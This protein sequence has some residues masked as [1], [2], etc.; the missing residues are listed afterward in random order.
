[1]PKGRCKATTSKKGPCGQR[2][3]PSGYCH[4][5]N[6]ALVEAKR[7]EA[8]AI[9]AKSKRLNEALAVLTDT[10]EARGWSW[11]IESIDQ[12]DYRY[13]SFNVSRLIDNGSF[14][15]QVT[16]LCEVTVDS[17]VKVSVQKTSFHGYG[18]TVL[19]DAFSDALGRLPWLESP[20]KKPT[21]QTGQPPAP[22][23]LEPL[24]RRFPQIVRQLRRRH[25]DRPT[26]EISDEYD[27]QD[28]LHAV[29]RGLFNDVR[30]EESTPSYA[31]GAARM[32]FLLK[33]EKTVVETK[34][35]TAKLKDK[36]I[37]EQL[38]IDIQRYRTHPDCQRLVCFVY[39]PDG[40]VKNPEGLEK[41]LSG[42]QGN[43]EVKVIVAPR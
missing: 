5:H 3:G 37:G 33:N 25:D 14:G 1:M 42:K 22:E 17:G 35:A 10:C 19:R 20:T 27:V 43:L 26:L 32:D 6:P 28:L 11:V 18:M 4:L 7:K 23:R 15:E 24:F 8:E 39:D 29:L 30:S 38:I 34:M 36:L 13:A 41:D 21:P 40:N 2:A 9:T 31:G 12:K 16:G